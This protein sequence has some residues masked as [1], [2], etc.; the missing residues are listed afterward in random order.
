MNNS[1][2]GIEERLKFYL[3]KQIAIL[4]KVIGL[5]LKND[6]ISNRFMEFLLNKF[7]EVSLVNS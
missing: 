6:K 7:N 5:W 3:S 4:E 2:N 1:S